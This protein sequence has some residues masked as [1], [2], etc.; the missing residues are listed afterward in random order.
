MVNSRRKG[1]D[2]ER[3][4]ANIFKKYGYAD[5][6]RGQQYCGISGDADVV[7][8][9][10]IHVEAKAVEKLNLYDAMSQSKRDA[11]R[12]EIPVVVHKKNRQNIL[13]TMELPDFMTLY[14]EFEK[15]Y[16]NNPSVAFSDSSL[17]R[18][19]AEL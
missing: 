3:K 4:L 17:R 1:A 11:K 15:G 9:P 18:L 2:F 8:L 5:S 12:D 7:G 14:R 19:R 6:R 16:K 13:V 10:H